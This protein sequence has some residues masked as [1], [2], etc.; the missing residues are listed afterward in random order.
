MSFFYDKTK[1]YERLKNLDC[2]EEVLIKQLN[3]FYIDKETRKQYFDKLADVKCWK[4]ELRD[5][6]YF[7]NEL[8]KSM[9]KK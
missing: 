2:E 6:I 8:E 7:L 1:L 9:M 5:K 4:K 3:T